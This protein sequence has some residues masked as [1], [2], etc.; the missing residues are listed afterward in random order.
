MAVTRK[1]PVKRATKP[2]TTPATARKRTPKKRTHHHPELWGLGMVAVGLFLATVLWLGWDG[3]TVGAT[4]VDGLHG[5]FGVAAYLIPLVLISVGVLM[6]V[7]SRL[8]DLKPFRTGLVVG[9][10]GLMIALGRDEGGAIGGALGGGLAH[11]IGETGA[12]IVGVA[13]FIAGTLAL[14][15]R[16]CRRRSAPLRHARCG[17]PATQPAGRSTRGTRRVARTTTGYDDARVTP[18]RPPV[19]AVDELPRRD[20][21][22][23]L[24]RRG[25]A[26]RRAGRRVHPGRAHGGR[27]RG[28][29]L[30]RRRRRA[31]TACPSARCSRPRRRSSATT[32]SRAPRSP[33]SS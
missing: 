22:R 5:A 2:R 14:H 8:V 32:A 25:A 17:T 9:A 12:L 19:D 20:R 21:S 26:A 10:F 24:L 27:R 13:L 23:C 3:G 18:R 7:R 1:K 6:L 28:D 29:R 15:R 30:R 33:I 4:V 11:V 16:L 31:T